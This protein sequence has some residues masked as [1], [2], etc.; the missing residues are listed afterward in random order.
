[1]RQELSPAEFRA[2][3][4]QTLEHLPPDQRDAF[5]AMMRQHRAP[6]A[7]R[8]GAGGASP[9]MASAA[10]GTTAVGADA[11]GGLLTGLMGG[12]AAGTGEGTESATR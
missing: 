8:D 3:L 7:T 4:Q 11:F 6:R 10:P 5:I 2:A 12:G 1:M 9:A